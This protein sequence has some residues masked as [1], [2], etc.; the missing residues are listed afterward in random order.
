MEFLHKLGT[1]GFH[2]INLDDEQ[3]DAEFKAAA[4]LSG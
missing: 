3:I 4:E 1:Y 2:A